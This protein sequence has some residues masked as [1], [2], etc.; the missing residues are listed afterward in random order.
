MI[1]GDM[2]DSVFMNLKGNDI[3]S[4]LIDFMNYSQVVRHI[5]DF[6]ETICK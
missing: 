6:N 4:A 2:D 1:H 3:K 5:I